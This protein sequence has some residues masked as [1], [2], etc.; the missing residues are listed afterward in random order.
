M[1]HSLLSMTASSVEFQGTSNSNSTQYMRYILAYFM[2]LG[3]P[4]TTDQHC[5][6][7]ELS[8][9]WTGAASITPE[10]VGLLTHA[11]AVNCIMLGDFCV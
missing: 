5:A 11:Q 9:A 3:I 10:G 8:D 7:V 1:N 2:A 4:W 6:R